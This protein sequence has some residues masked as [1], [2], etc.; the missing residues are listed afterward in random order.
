[1][2]A[3]TRRVVLGATL[4][5][6]NSNSFYST[7]LLNIHWVLLQNLQQL[8]LIFETKDTHHGGQPLLKNV[9]NSTTCIF[10]CSKSPASHAERYSTIIKTLG[11]SKC[12][13]FGHCRSSQLTDWT[14][15]SIWKTICWAV[16]FNDASAHSISQRARWTVPGSSGLHHCTDFLGC[17]FLKALNRKM[18]LLWWKSYKH[19]VVLRNTQMYAAKAIDNIL[20][21]SLD[22]ATSKRQPV[23][24]RRIT[25]C[26]GWDD[27][28]NFYVYRC[29][30][31][32]APSPSAK[33]PVHSWRALG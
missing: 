31:C 25:S 21:P 22:V 4:M 14:R 17:W 23:G 33:L 7:A 6:S 3:W 28:S 12:W 19:S 26:P 5:P 15:L 24:S 29:I 10:N 8:I 32:W 9:V 30:R 16:A 20:V 11:S 13:V 27:Y 18:S 1:M 2:C